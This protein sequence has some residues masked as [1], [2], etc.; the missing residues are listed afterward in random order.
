MDEDQRDTVRH[1]LLTH[2]DQTKWKDFIR[3]RYDNPG[4]L[5]DINSDD[6]RNKMMSM[7]IT[8]L[9]GFATSK[10]HQMFQSAED[11]GYESG[12]KPEISKL[13]R[14]YLN[15]PFE[16]YDMSFIYKGELEDENPITASISISDAIRYLK[17]LGIGSMENLGITSDYASTTISLWQRMLDDVKLRPIVVPPGLG[18]GVRAG[19]PSE[20]FFDKDVALNKLDEL[21]SNRK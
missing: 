12:L 2:I 11:A 10:A 5:L 20:E 8:G 7:S 13:V 9:F 6:A 15:R 3:Y 21:M 17:S 1:Y 14:N 16:D 19:F 18:I 4:K